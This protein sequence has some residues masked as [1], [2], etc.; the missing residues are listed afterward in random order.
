MHRAQKQLEVLPT[1]GFSLFEITFISTSALQSLAD[2]VLGQAG[3]RLEPK[4][5]FLVSGPTWTCTDQKDAWAARESK[6]DINTISP[7]S[8]LHLST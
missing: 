5:S 1:T 7:G 8:L 4:L 6:T 2:P 3:A